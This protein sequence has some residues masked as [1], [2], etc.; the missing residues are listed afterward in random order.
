MEIYLR[1]QIDVRGCLFC[2]VTLDPS[3]ANLNHIILCVVAEEEINN[4]V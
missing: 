2:K 1:T 4:P 3:L